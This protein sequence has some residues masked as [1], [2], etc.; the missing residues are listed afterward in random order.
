MGSVA[1]YVSMPGASPYAMS[2]FAVRALAQSL[3]HELRASGVSVTL[4]S[5]GFVDSE[6]RQIDNKGVYREGSR[7][8][9]PRIIRMPTVPAA[10]KMA[11][12]IAR[13]RREVVITPFG[14]FVVFLAHYGRPLVELII[15]LGGVHGRREPG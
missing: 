8:P 1:G 15:R 12:A 9:V 5:P 10:R 6:I 11:R 3:R 13:R 14:K 7:E 2:K 4:I